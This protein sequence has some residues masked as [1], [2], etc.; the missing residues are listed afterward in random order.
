M[1]FSQWLQTVWKCLPEVCYE[2]CFPKLVKFFWPF[3]SLGSKFCAQR[4]KKPSSIHA[5]WPL[6]PTQ[7]LDTVLWRCEI[8]SVWTRC[9]TCCFSCCFCRGPKHWQGLIPKWT[10]SLDSN[11]CLIWAWLDVWTELIKHIN[12][13][14]KHIVKQNTHLDKNSLM[15][16]PWWVA[17]S[18]PFLASYQKPIWWNQHQYQHSSQQV[19]FH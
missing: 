16:L 11:A 13:A 2:S 4:V 9:K 17:P 3:V 12:C 18:S 6:P 19:P 15:I 7:Q 1:G 8:P 14:H 5:R 10:S